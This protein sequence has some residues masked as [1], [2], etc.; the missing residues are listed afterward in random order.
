MK[1]LILILLSISIISCKKECKI[2]SYS[3]NGGI[4]INLNTDEK[5]KKEIL[6]KFT[7]DEQNR[8]ATKKFEL[9]SD[10]YELYF[11]YDLKNR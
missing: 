6:S 2:V 9:S 7:L 3:E 5:T 8:I 1:K 11:N 10:S 4:E